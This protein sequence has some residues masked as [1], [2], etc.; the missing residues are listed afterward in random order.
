LTENKNDILKLCLL[1]E[2]KHT[3]PLEWWTT[4]KFYSK[5]TKHV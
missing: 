5:Q 2:K 3:K 1:G 4:H